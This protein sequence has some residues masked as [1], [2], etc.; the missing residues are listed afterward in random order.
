MRPETPDLMPARLDLRPERPDLRSKRPDLR[1]QRPDLRRE[2]PDK[3]AGGMNRWKN[4]QTNEQT[5]KSV[6]Q[7]FVPLGPAAQKVN[8]AQFFSIFALF[9]CPCLH[10]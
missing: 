1:S 5:N 4:K 3:E 2:G 8:A 9:S 10:F 7:D 6:L